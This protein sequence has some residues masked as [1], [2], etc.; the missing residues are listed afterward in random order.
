MNLINVQKYI[1][2]IKLHMNEKKAKQ[3]SWY[4][5]TVVYLE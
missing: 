5:T 2:W 3:Q 1:H 4:D